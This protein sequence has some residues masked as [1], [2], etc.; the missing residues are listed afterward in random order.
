MD[1]LTITGSHY[2]ID[3][4]DMTLETHRTIPHTGPDRTGPDHTGTSGTTVGAIVFRSGLLAFFLKARSPSCLRLVES[5][6][7]GGAFCSSFFLRFGHQSYQKG[8]PHQLLSRGQCT[9]LLGTIH[10]V[11]V[12]HWMGEKV[13]VGTQVGS[14]T[15]SGLKSQQQ[16]KR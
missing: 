16:Q 7:V 5:P 9:A 1:L 15:G 8:G 4:V 2:I 11:G 14:H 3:T 12:V 10:P 13:A 6:S